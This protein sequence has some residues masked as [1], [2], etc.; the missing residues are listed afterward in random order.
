M[1]RAYSKEG[2]KGLIDQFEN[3][4]RLT[5]ATALPS[6]AI[7]SALA[8]PIVTIL[9][10]RGAW[11]HSD[12]ISVSRI[13][14][15]V[16]IGDVLFRMVINVI[17]RAYYVVK[18]TLTLPL[19]SASS[20]IVYY[21]L[22]KALTNSWGYVGLAAAYPIQRGVIAVVVGITFILR[23]KSMPGRKLLA[24]SL[25]YITASGISALSAHLITVVLPFHSTLL[26][27]FFALVG[28]GSIYMLILYWRDRETAR[29]VLE[30]TGLPRFISG[31]K[32]AHQSI[33][34]LRG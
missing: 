33:S 18:D 24:D 9:Y 2:E 28:S 7:L 4:L 19:I 26:Q 12:T 10:E 20:T 15:I 17:G 16:M 22:G 29:S 11:D 21:F 8:I 5:M 27:L 31:L 13:V 32:M 3:G 6:I 14:F 1:A 34:S 23:F 25:L 30:I